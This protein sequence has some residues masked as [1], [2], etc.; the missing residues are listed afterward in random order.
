MTPDLAHLL[1]RASESELGISV[2]TNNPQLLR[3][4]LYAE[5]K[6]Y[7]EFGGLS[8]IQPPINPESTIW[9]IKKEARNGAAE[10]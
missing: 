5:R 3:N 9:I 1:L 10:D 7:P 8:F 2:T 4:R 6:K